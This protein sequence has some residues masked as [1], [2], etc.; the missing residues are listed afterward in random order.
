MLQSQKRWCS[1]MN[2]EIFMGFD[3]NFHFGIRR[4]L[5]QDVIFTVV[6]KGLSQV[7]ARQ[8]VGK[9]KFLD[10]LGAQPHLWKPPGL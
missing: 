7:A 5:P 8:L 9:S 10:D 6:E 1:L 4:F 2:Y 3:L